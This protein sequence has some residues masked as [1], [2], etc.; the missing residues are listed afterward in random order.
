MKTYFIS[1]SSSSGAIRGRDITLTVPFSTNLDSLTAEFYHTGD[2]AKLNSIEQISGSTKNNYNNPLT[3]RITAKNKTTLDYIVKTSKGSPT[4]NSLL[5]FSLGNNLQINSYSGIITGSLVT[6]YVPNGTDLTSL[7][8]VFSHNGKKVQVGGVDQTSSKSKLSFSSPVVYSVFSEAGAK[9]DY[10]VS[11]SLGSSD[12][13]EIKAFWLDGLQ[14]TIIGTDILLGVGA[15]K[16]YTSLITDFIHTGVEVKIS[17]KSTIS[18]E[19]SFDYSSPV[20]V[21]VVAK[22]GSTKDYKVIVSSV[23]AFS[24]GGIVSGL[25]SGKI[26][27]LQ[28]NGGDNAIIVTNGNFSLNTTVPNYGA[29][30]VTVLINPVNQ[31]CTVTNGTGTANSNVTNII[32]DCNNNPGTTVQSF[33]DNGDQT[34]RDNNTGLIWM[35]CTMSNVSGVPQSG[36]GC[37]T[38][39]VGTYAFCSTSN[40]NC[41]GGV[42][43]V[44]L[45]PPAWIGGSTSSLWTACDNANTTPSG[46]FAGRTNWRVPTRD[47]LFTLVDNSRINPVINITYF[48]NTQSNNYWSSTTYAP[49]TIS[50]WVV[51]FNGGGLIDSNKTNNIFYVRCVSGP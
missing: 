17:G 39:T 36:A 12:A 19:N 4:S 2:T 5:A 24:V 14:A 1:E 37:A 48:P 25:G 32:V 51:N 33:T 38:G 21:T 15:D 29:Y 44:N 43:T 50:A 30:N 42:S 11:V 26:L 13:K 40:N 31:F 8:A 41:N 46:G 22:D 23:N 9:Q 18:G 6:V 45:Q 20:I 49:L 7:T 34:I 27:I 3:Y 47:E 16:N 10:T 28:N 35:K